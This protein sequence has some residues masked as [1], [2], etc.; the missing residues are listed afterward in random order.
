[1]TSSGITAREPQQN[2]VLVFSITLT[3]KRVRPSVWIILVLHAELSSVRALVKGPPTSHP[4][5]NLCAMYLP[6]CMQTHKALVILDGLQ[7]CPL[8]PP[9]S[10]RP[11]CRFAPVV[12]LEASHLAPLA[13][14]RSSEAADEAKKL[15][16]A[17]A[18]AAERLVDVT[19]E[20]EETATA[21]AA[22]AALSI[23]TT[24][25]VLFSR[26]LSHPKHSRPWLCRGRGCRGGRRERTHTANS[27]RVRRQ[28]VRGSG[29]SPGLLLG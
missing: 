1:V 21:A 2:P 23:S 24:I 8:A 13:E 29:Q 25:R 16:D 14:A 6:C 3:Q 18:L 4:L 5:S 26:T 15:V 27:M 7:L 22:A 11:H 28:V 19:K 20:A 12:V 9:V 17:A 10:V